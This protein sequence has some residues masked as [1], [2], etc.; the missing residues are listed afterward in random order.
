MD[1]IKIDSIE[2]IRNPELQREVVEGK[3]TIEDAEL[4]INMWSLYKYIGMGL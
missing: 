2:Q 3:K 4:E 1:E